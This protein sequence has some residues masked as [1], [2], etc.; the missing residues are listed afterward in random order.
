MAGTN[1]AVQIAMQI[2][3]EANLVAAHLL[4]RSSKWE[5]IRVHPG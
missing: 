1:S 5:G 2:A 4:R 3:I